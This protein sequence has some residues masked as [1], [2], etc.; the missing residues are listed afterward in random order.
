MAA[1]I[2]FLRA[3]PLS[4]LQGPSR[5]GLAHYGV[6]PCFAADAISLMQ[7]NQLLK[8]EPLAP[9]VEMALGNIELRFAQ[10]V[11]VALCG[12]HGQIYLDGV[13]VPMYRT[14][15]VEAGQHL[16]IGPLTQGN[17]IYLGMA[18][19]LHVS[20]SFASPSCSV[21]EELGANQGRPYKNGDVIQGKPLTDISIQTIPFAQ[22]L[23]Y[24]WQLTLSLVP[25]YQFRQLPKGLKQVF[26]S[27][28]F[29]VSAESGRMGVRLAGVNLP[30]SQLRL[31]SEGLGLGAV[32][33]PDN[34]Q[35]IVMLGE[36]QTLGG[37]PKIGSV[38]E[39]DCAR[40]AQARP[41][42]KVRFRLLSR[43]AAN[44]LN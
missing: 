31:V 24:P 33:I 7:V 26:F 17:Y 35:P 3:G 18:A 21:R 39:S 38:I 44:H 14:F 29:T 27:Q 37:Y 43:F 20:T 19:H 36:H 11:Q 9:C 12:G 15:K 23:T 8:R 10:T 5:A 22:R 1:L 13:R 25:G 40:L 4:T 6:S 30:S 16:R 42:T 2:E 28:P 32:Q 34:G 41:G